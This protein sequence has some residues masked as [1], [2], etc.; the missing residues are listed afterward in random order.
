MAR[1]LVPGTLMSS[2][3]VAKT[4]TSILDLP[5]S[6]LEFFGVDKP[7]QMVGSSIFSAV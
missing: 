5:V 1:D 3:K 6:I 7:E 4:R 2:Q